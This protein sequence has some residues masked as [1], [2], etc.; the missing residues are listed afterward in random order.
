MGGRRTRL[1]EKLFCSFFFLFLFLTGCKVF[2][3]GRKLLHERGRAF[4]FLSEFF[5]SIFIVFA[6]LLLCRAVLSLSC[7]PV[8]TRTIS[9]EQNKYPIPG[10]CTYVRHP[11]REPYVASEQFSPEAWRPDSWHYQVASLQL[12]CTIINKLY[13]NVFNDGPFSASHFLFS[14]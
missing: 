5:G 3:S 10:V 13:S 6:V 8:R 12:L 11:R 14:F 9:K 7:I 1:G 2:Q 4:V